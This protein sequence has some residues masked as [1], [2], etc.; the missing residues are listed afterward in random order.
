MF[1]AINKVITSIHGINSNINN[2]TIESLISRNQIPDKANDVIIDMIP[3]TWT[4][5]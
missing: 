5:L 1:E 3:V 2:F 4:S